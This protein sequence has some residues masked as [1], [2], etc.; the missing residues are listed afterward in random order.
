MASSA[1]V[2]GS[3]EYKPEM[4]MICSQMN[5]NPERYQNGGT[6]SSLRQQPGIARQKTNH[7]STVQRSPAIVNIGHLESRNNYVRVMPQQK[8]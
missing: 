5:I 6:N 3:V 7:S 1:K 2:K 8:M 4:L